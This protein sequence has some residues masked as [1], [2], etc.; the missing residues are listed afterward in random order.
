M[1]GERV[2]DFLIEHGVQFEINFAQARLYGLLYCSQC[3]RSG[4][5]ND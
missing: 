1:I 4:R 3:T 2:K 5:G